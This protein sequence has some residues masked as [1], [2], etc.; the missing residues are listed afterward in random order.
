MK[1]NRFWNQLFDR[2][3]DDLVISV[4]FNSNNIWFP[5]S[6]YFL[7]RELKSLKKKVEFKFYKSKLN[8]AIQMIE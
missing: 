8:H 4:G 2:I 3:V 5:E 6:S 7:L 1:S